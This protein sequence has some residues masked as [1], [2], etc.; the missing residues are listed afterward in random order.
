MGHGRPLICINAAQ[1]VTIKNVRQ[2]D[3]TILKTN[4]AIKIVRASAGEAFW[5]MGEK[6]NFK[7]KAEDTGGAFSLAEVTA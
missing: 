4:S 5:A 3:Q 1:F 6:L 2:P 7:L